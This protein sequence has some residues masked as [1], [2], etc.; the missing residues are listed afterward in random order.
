M[1]YP[2][3][4][5]IG[6][7]LLIVSTCAFAQT[8]LSLNLSKTKTPGDYYA[9]LWHLLLNEIDSANASFSS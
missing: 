2:F 7:G 8:N 9:P 3:R 5:L 1:A 4:M 6:R